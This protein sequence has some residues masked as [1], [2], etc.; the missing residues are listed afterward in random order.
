[1]GP[2]DPSTLPISLVA[3]NPSI[4][5]APVILVKRLGRRR[6]LLATTVTLLLLAY[7]FVA[8]RTRGP[9]LPPLYER[10]HKYESQLPQHN[11]NLPYPEARNTKYIWISNHVRSMRRDPSSHD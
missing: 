8:E 2:S 10:Y 11:L 9:R 5:R 6:T 3:K 4:I 7:F 1:M